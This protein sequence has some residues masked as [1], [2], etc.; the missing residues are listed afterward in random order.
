MGLQR[1]L[2]GDKGAGKADALA[3]GLEF[4]GAGGGEGLLGPN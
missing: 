3:L 4:L 1:A 2:G